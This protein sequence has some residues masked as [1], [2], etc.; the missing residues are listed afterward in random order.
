M[1]NSKINLPNIKRVKLNF[2]KNIENLN[3]I[4]LYNNFK[5]IYK[6]MN[7]LCQ[8]RNFSIIKLLYII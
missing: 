6:K 2:R 7:L 1:K 3:M 8:K 5:L 4:N